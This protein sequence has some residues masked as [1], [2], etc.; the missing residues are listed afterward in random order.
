MEGITLQTLRAVAEIVGERFGVVV[1]VD[2]DEALPDLAAHRNQPE[3]RLVEVEELALL[4]DEGQIAL[5]R[6]APGVVLAGELTARAGHLL[7]R[8]VVPHQLVSAVAAHVV[9]RPDLVV[10]VLDDD[11]RRSGA[12]RRHLSCEV[13]SLLGE[14]LHPADVQPALLE[15]CLLL[16]LPLL[17]VDRVSVVDR[18]GTEF[19]PVLCPATGLW[20]RE[21]CHGISYLSSSG[22]TP[23]VLMATAS[24]P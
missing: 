9:E 13:A 24:A 5:Q 15:D 1:E 10:G 11:H 16:E 21:E 4:L 18:C 6:V 8:I 12:G 22:C 3:V 7:T 14:P 20:L 23:K 19:W 2:E 17:R